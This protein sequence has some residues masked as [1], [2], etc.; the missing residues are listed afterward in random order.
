MDQKHI[1]TLQHAMATRLYAVGTVIAQEPTMAAGWLLACE[2]VARALQMAYPLED[3]AAFLNA[4][5]IIL[6]SEM[7]NGGLRRSR[8]AVA[9][10]AAT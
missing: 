2:A 5:G 10:T 8:T 4:C 7:A 9:C 3:A 1:N 6:N